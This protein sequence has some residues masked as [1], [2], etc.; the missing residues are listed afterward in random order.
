MNTPNH[1][2][3]NVKCGI[4]FGEAGSPINGELARIRSNVRANYK[5][6]L[7]KL[8]FEKDNIAKLK[9]IDAIDSNSHRDFWR[10]VKKVQG[11]GSRSASSI[12]G[13]NNDPGIANLFAGK[14]EELYNLDSNRGD[15]LELSNEID[16]LCFSQ[17]ECC[18]TVND[19]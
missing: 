15:I 11:T 14:Y 16:D 17:K 12:D 6:G 8:I 4:S 9:M 5:L 13:I 7:R 18:Y 3:R 2:A 19:I 10:E 1:C